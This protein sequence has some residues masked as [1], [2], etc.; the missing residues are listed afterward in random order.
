MNRYKYSEA[1][2]S[3]IENSVV[4][5]AV[6]QYIDKKVEALAFSKGFLELFGYEN[7]EDVYEHLDKNMH[8]NVHP[9]DVARVFETV[10]RFA[11]EETEYNI[12]YRLKIKDSYHVIHA[13]GK[14]TYPEVDTRL[15][16]IWY[17]DEGEYIGD[18]DVN[19][20]D[21]SREVS[22]SIYE[23][24]E[25]RKTNYDY[26]T[27]LPNMKYFFEL[28]KT[29]RIAIHKNGQ[30]CTLGFTNLNGMKYYNQK[31]GFIEGDNLLRKFGN[32]LLK[33]FG[34]ECVCRFGQDNFAFITVSDNV[35][36][37]I[38]EI[39]K[40]LD[41]MTGDR[42]MSVR[43]GLYP[44][45]MGIVETNLACDRARNACNTMRNS[46][47]SC[48]KYFD[49]SMLTY[50]MNRRYVLDNLDKA[51]EKGWIQAYYQPIVRAANGKVCDE[52][53]LA[54]W[55]DPIK[56]VLSPAEFIPVLEDAKLIY[57]VDLHMVD[58]ILERMKEQKKTGLYIVPVSVNLSRTDFDACDIV[59]EI[60]DRV[61]AAGISRSKLTIEITESVVGSDFDFIKRQV[62]RFKALGFQVWMDDFG[63]GY[64][65]LDVLQSIHFDVIKLDM[66]F[67]KQFGN[68][69]KNHIILTELIKMAIGL[70]IDTVCEG[71]ETEE[72]VEFL[73]EVGCTKL[74]GYYFCKPVPYEM[75]LERNRK[76]IQIGFENPDESEYYETLGKVNLYDISIVMNDDS[77]NF[78]QY[79]NT[80]PMAILEAD[81]QG[82]KVTRCN[83]SYRDFLRVAFD[84]KFLEVF[85]PY[86][87]LLSGPGS[88]FA[89]TVATAVERGGRYFVDERMDNN[90]TIHAIV[91]RIV[92]NPVTGKTAIAVVVLGIIKDSAQ[93]ITYADI[94]NSLS[95]DYLNLYYVDVYDDTFVEYKPND[96]KDN[97]SIERHGTDFFDASRM[98][99]LDFIYKEDVQKFVSAFNKE[100]VLG[101]I[102]T[103]G[104]FTLTYRL[105]INGEPIYVHMKA[106]RMSNDDEH[107]II[108][109]NNIDAQMKAQ[110]AVERMR[111][112]RTTYARI[113]AL[114][115]NYICIYTVNPA[116]N[117][118]VEYGATEDYE[119]IG[120]QKTGADFFEISKKESYRAVHPDDQELFRKMLTK[121]NVLREIEK[122]G[123]FILNYR[124]IINDK[125]VYTNLR[126]ALVEEKD[127]PQLIVGVSN[128]DSQVRRDMDFS[129]K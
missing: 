91:R 39:F 112:E 45:T 5:F 97:L 25:H 129:N 68:D 77:Q 34:S 105:L 29:R 17:V 75:I 33:H 122:N 60:C 125:P 81:E 128:V 71:V 2:L 79:F 85:T 31:Y 101:A 84:I 89:D 63:S 6:F 116:T 51:L 38:K 118:Y 108:G 110:E 41:E 50:E 27:G 66:K 36:P 69:E 120:L 19:N 65:S 12:V 37:A 99:A 9:D 73:R 35:L 100:N 46:G 102:D 52:E 3:M 13:F 43:I 16:T 96:S 67:M 90:N 107:I 59:K 23:D 83:Q 104:K 7:S 4:P 58:Q 24:S 47:R 54:R 121:E 95:A 76:G 127:G 109:V 48:Y 20:E 94:A 87:Q 123:V 57:K 53:A 28:A 61:D 126:V 74:Q 114:S 22:W 124:T 11:N 117:E 10:T 18:T 115:G 44:D 8:E 26:L 111:E 92:V 49:D 15:A 119:G 64:S 1:E 55:V 93:A 62:D 56:G 21:L 14:H 113:T 72:Q 82:M 40:E 88:L 42:K 80:M 70:G 32:V 98:D 103:Y 86:E 106:I 78:T 30:H